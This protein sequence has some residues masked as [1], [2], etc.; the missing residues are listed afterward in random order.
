GR[1]W[2]TAMMCR[3]RLI[4][5]LPARES[6]WRR[7]WP[8][9][10]SSGAVAVPGREVSAAGE[11]GDV[12][13]VADEPGG[14]G[15][16]D[17][18]QCLDLAAGTLDQLGELA[19]RGLDLRIDGFDLLDQLAG[20]LVTGAPDQVGGFDGAQQGAGLAGGQVL[21]RP[22]GDQVEQEHVQPVDQIGAGA[23]EG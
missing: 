7:C 10:A 1:S 20:E 22:A 19:I 6:R 16:A 4:R 21:L 8:D 12:T 23:S 14:A 3:T 13:D 17:A 5:R 11:P 2:T 15:R 9:E 18:V